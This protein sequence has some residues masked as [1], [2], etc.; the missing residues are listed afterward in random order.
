MFSSDLWQKLELAFELKSLTYETL[1]WIGVGSGLLMKNSVRFDRLRALVLL[2][3]KWLGLFLKKNHLL[4]TWGCFSVLNWIWTLS[5]S[6]LL[7]YHQ[8]NWSLDSFYEVFFFAEV[9]QYLYKSTIWN[10]CHAWDGPPNCY[11]EY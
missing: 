6:L 10:C 5:F 4:K 8:K 9:A 11:L 2:M 1:L 3:R 7:K